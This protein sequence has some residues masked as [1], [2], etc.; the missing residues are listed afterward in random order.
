LLVACFK[1]L[2]L[3]RGK[4]VG[5]LLRLLDSLFDVEQAVDHAIG[6]VLLVLLM[7]EDQFPQVV[8]VA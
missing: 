8:G 6:P 1:G 2:D 4:M 7:H 3:V 5:D